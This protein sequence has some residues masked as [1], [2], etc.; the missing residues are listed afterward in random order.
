MHRLLMA[1]VLSLWA[2]APLLDPPAAPATA[3]SVEGHETTVAPAAPVSVLDHVVV[4]GA[5]I[6]AGF[7]TSGMMGLPALN[8]ADVLRAML[9]DGARVESFADTLLFDEPAARSS[10]QV[11]RARKA[12]P[13]AIIAV[14]FPFWWS[15]GLWFDEADR[16]AALERG[17]KMLLEARECAGAPGQ[18]PAPI[19]IAL[20]P[21][22]RGLTGPTV[23]HPLQT[24][25]ADTLARC[26]QRLCEW[27]QE[28]EGIIIVPLLED[29]NRLRAKEKVEIGETSLDPKEVALLQ[30]DGLHTTIEGL[31]F[32]A[33][34]CVES[35]QAAGLIEPDRV[36]YRDPAGLARRLRE[37]GVKPATGSPR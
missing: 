29:F 23:P 27:A 28:N 2:P 12:A 11:T 10:R 7:N 3:P 33:C 30:P 26:N 8:L 5:S 19:L 32:V 6:S 18:P 1:A 22:T 13:T 14:D 24:P 37:Q 31:A 35:M 21:D 16:L 9:P 20:L 4:M 25:D 15:Y 34:R 17:L 36:D